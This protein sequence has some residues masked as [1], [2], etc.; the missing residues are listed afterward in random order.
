M[1]AWLDSLVNGGVGNGFHGSGMS[2][3]PLTSA[4]ERG[5]W[6]PRGRPCG[7]R[8]QPKRCW[9]AALGL[10]EVLSVWMTS[11]DIFCGS[12]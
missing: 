10:A 7:W 4:V 9:H 3:R 6:Q 11:Q 8:R 5:C 12:I 1:A 2:T